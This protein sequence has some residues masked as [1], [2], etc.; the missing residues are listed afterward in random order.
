[1]ADNTGITSKAAVPVVPVAVMPFRG[2]WLGRDAAVEAESLTFQ[3]FDTVDHEYLRWLLPWFQFQPPLVP[4]SSQKRHLTGCPRQ[5]HVVE[6]GGEIRL[7][8]HGP[9]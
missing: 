8:D 1:M 4:N 7:I 2:E 9:S 5:L 3:S 6:T